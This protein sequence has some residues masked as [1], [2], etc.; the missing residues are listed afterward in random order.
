MAA[1]LAALYVVTVVF[2]AYFPD[3]ERVPAFDRN[4]DPNWMMKGPLLTLVVAA[5]AVSALSGPLIELLNR[6]LN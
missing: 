3:E 4:M 5:V 6:L 2:H 1:L